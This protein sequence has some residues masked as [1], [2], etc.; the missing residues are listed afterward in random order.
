MEAQ[1]KQ[2]EVTAQSEIKNIGKE[3]GEKAANNL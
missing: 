1:N 3:M 2:E